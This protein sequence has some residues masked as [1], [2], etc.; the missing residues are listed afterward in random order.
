MRLPVTP[1]VHSRSSGR[2]QRER[3]DRLFSAPPVAVHV[4]RDRLDAPPGELLRDR[5]P[6]PAPVPETVNKSDFTHVQE[7]RKRPRGQPHIVCTLLTGTRPAARGALGADRI[8]ACIPERGVHLGLRRRGLPGDSCDRGGR[9]EAKRRWSSAGRRTHPTASCA[10][11]APGS[12]ILGRARRRP[13]PRGHHPDAVVA[14]PRRR[15]R[16]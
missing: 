9:L 11:V 12:H 13:Y 2:S 7:A 10:S 3:G 14:G 6:A 15:L 4:D 8:A 16:I 1:A 5:A